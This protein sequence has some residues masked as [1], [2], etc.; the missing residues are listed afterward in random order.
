M[1][2]Y[3][4]LAVAIIIFG[5]LASYFVYISETSEGHAWYRPFKLGLDLSGGTHLVYKADVSDVAEGSVSEAMTALKEVIERRINVF[6]VSEPLIQVEQVG[7]GS[8]AHHKL[9]VELPGVTDIN[10]ALAIIDKTPI[11]EF[12]LEKVNRPSDEE[13]TKQIESIQKSDATT[14]VE[15]VNSLTD[16]LYENSGLSGKY[17]EKAQVVF[18]SAGQPGAPQG[19]SI[20]IQFNEEGAK[21][22]AQITRDNTGKV[23]AIFLDGEL[24]SAPVIQGEI[25]NGE[26]QITGQFTIEEARELTGNLNLGALPVP[27]QLDSTQTIGPTLGQNVLNQGVYAGLIGFLI[28]AAYMIFWYRLPGLVSVVSLVFYIVIMLLLFKLI[29][30]T[31]TAAG[32][33]GFILSV[34]IAVDANI[35]IFERMKEELKSG[36]NLHEAIVEGFSRAWLPIRDSN[37]SGVISAVVLFWFGTSMIKG[38]ALTLL[39]GILV[40]MFSAITLTRTMLVALGLRHKSRLINFLF[41]NGLKL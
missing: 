32:I 36:K 24:L 20:L 12:K 5:A 18:A 17:L 11:L 4:I 26:A 39:I 13:I 38:F 23:L 19:P 34:G 1:K 22:M 33:A 31:I 9:I 16:A 15:L 35:L 29:P 7:L 27:I 25:T 41:G 30:I 8:N 28:L 21:L 3:R 2:L 40:S 6:G 37:L 10:E 14:S